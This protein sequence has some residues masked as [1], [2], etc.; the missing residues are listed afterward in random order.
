MHGIAFDW[1]KQTVKIYMQYSRYFSCNNDLCRAMLQDYLGTYSSAFCQLWAWKKAFEK[2]NKCQT[3]PKIWG[4]VLALD[5][6]E[7]TVKMGCSILHGFPVRMTCAELCWQISWEH[8]P[9]LCVKF[10]PWRR[11]LGTMFMTS[12]Y[13]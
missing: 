6:L 3:Q 4:L 13:F 10:E 1:P 12:A 7:Q 9:Q 11:Q 2:S 8:F 5:W